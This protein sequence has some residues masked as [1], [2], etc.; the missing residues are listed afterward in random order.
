MAVP[1]SSAL[2][3]KPGAC[4]AP[5]FSLSPIVIFSPSPS[6]PVLNCFTESFASCPRE[7]LSEP[8]QERRARALRS[9]PSSICLSSGYATAP[10]LFALRSISL[11]TL[12][13]TT[14]TTPRKMYTRNV[15][16]VTADT[17]CGFLDRA[18]RSRPAT[19][20]MDS[21]SGMLALS[22]GRGHS[23]FF[24]TFVMV[25]TTLFIM[26]VPVSLSAPILL[27]LILITKSTSYPTLIL[28]VLLSLPLA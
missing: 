17:R 3:T 2:L 4:A 19:D 13:V 9:R 6:A 11:F 18:A 20:K 25:Q 28:L 12:E 26:D 22:V 1:G 5:S 21:R 23:T 14:W 15:S 27:H 24:A 7:R 10:D 8:L 16:Q